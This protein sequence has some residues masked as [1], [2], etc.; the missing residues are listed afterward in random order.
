MSVVGEGHE[1]QDR[2]RHLDGLL[3]SAEKS[4]DPAGKTRLCEIVQEISSLHGA[5]LERVLQHLGEAGS[6]GQA[7][8]DACT[9]D[10]VVGGLLLLHGLHPQDLETRVNQALDSVRPYLQSH[11]GNVELLEVSEE[12]VRLKL[13]GSCHHCPS[14]TATMHHTVEEAI[15]ARAPDVAAIEVEGLAPE[16][17]V[18]QETGARIALPLL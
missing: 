4:A 11:G 1:I 14:S 5:G 3:Q 7:I 17:P 10:Q 13:E 2:L 9:A 12:R 8:L 15:L 16:F 6:S 18:G